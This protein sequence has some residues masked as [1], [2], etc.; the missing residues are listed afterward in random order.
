MGIR[1]SVHWRKGYPTTKMGKY[2]GVFV[3]SGHKRKKHLR[4]SFRMM[5]AKQIQNW[6]KNP[7]PG[8]RF[9]CSVILETVGRAPYEKRIM[10]LIKLGKPKKA[11]K[12]AKKRLGTHKRAKRKRN[13]LDKEQQRLNTQAQ[14]AAA[15]ARERAQARKAKKGAK[16][17]KKKD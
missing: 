4:K 12:V 3:K 9:V 8:R 10:E 17:S 13:L 5:R 1:R 6:K 11:L 7:K 2:A 14:M 15:K 16:E